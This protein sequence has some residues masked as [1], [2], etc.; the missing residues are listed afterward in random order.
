[1][2]GS[3]Q[4][5]GK[6]LAMSSSLRALRFRYH[7]CVW[8]TR[9]LARPCDADPFGVGA[10]AGCDRSRERGSGSTAW[11]F[12]GSR[13]RV[14][15]GLRGGSA[16]TVEGVRARAGCRE[17]EGQ[18]RRL[19]DECVQRSAVCRCCVSARAFGRGSFWRC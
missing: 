10:H 11:V 15:V 2:R 18:A 19:V 7:T 13:S 17:K 4:T 1:M 6:S 5:R 3:Q 14:T 16:E 8:L 12:F 9:A